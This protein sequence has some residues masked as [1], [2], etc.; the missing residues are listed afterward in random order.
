[1]QSSGSFRVGALEDPIDI[2]FFGRTLPMGFRGMVVTS[3]FSPS[4]VMTVTG[5]WR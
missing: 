3:N 1:M 2:M 4:S 5:R